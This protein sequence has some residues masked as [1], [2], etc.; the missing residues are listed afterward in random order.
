MACCKLVEFKNSLRGAGSVRHNAKRKLCDV[1]YLLIYLMSK[2]LHEGF[3]ILYR[4]CIIGLTSALPA[5][6]TEFINPI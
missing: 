2:K 4:T 5:G 1:I 6:P 3:H